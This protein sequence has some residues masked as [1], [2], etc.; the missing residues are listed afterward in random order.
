MRELF[1]LL[2]LSTSLVASDYIAEEFNEK[3]AICATFSLHSHNRIS[4]EKGG[5]LSV[6]GDK[7]LFAVEINDKIGQAFVYLLRDIETMPATLTLVSNSGYVQDLLV[8]S[9][10]KPSTFL[11]IQEPKEEE[12][13]LS[14]CDVDF[15]G[16]TI[17]FLTT[18][19]DGH[20]PFGYGKRLLKEEDQRSLPCPLEVSALS[21]LEGPFESVILYEVKNHGKKLV[22]F[23]PL[24]LKRADDSWVFSMKR[25][26]HRG[27]TTLFLVAK[28]KGE[29]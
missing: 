11:S 10:D 15:H 1:S 22:S 16:K 27:E 3:R 18:I 4:W 12:D 25:E 21:A 26:L 17:D 5:I 8:L 13:S 7:N 24:D 6:T 2:L 9:A 23:S 28:R 29:S 19:V 14:S 20:A